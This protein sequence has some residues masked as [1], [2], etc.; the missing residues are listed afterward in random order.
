MSSRSRAARGEAFHPVR[1]GSVAIALVLVLLIPGAGLAPARA[2]DCTRTSAGFTP[3]GDLGAGTYLGREGGLY[4]GGANE[5]PPA[6]SALGEALARLAVPRDA[7]GLP[8]PALGR[9]VFLSIGMSNT[10]QEFQRFL[11][12]AAAD[13]ARH[14]QVLVVDGAQ[15]G[16]DARRIADPLSPYWDTVNARLAA[17]GA[18]PL[19]VQ[20]VW[21]KEAVAGPSRAFPADAQELQGFLR[22]IVQILKDR[23]PN[24]WLTYV[25]SRI[26]AGYATTGLNPEPFA[27][28][29]G[30]AVKWLVEEQ[31]SSP[32]PLL[33][34]GAP[35]PWLSWGPYLWADGLVPRSD[36]LVWECADFRT[37]GTHPSSSGAQ[38][39]AGMLVDFLHSDST[40]HI[41]YTCAGAC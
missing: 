34:G 6:H 35:Q 21:L 37:D 18:T 33:T 19:Q 32:L 9:S 13:P 28:Q 26:Y 16:M 22:T 7:A 41:W 36:G 1:K 4:P 40:A 25:S 5:R 39:V 14:P 11:P 24:L 3:L 30:F 15:G 38:K 8:D 23:F 10:T 31:I 17:A 20:A 2:S 27:Y 29:S 12:L